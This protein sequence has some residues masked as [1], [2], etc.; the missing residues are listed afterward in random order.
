MSRRSLFLA[1][2]FLLPQTALSRPSAYRAQDPSASVVM[3]FARDA[4]GAFIFTGS[5]F[6]AKPGLVVSLRD[7]RRDGATVFVTRAG[8]DLLVPATPVPARGATSVDV[9]RVAKTRVSP[10]K[11]ASRGAT[12]GEAVVAD[13]ALLYAHAQPSGTMTSA[14]DA[15]VPAVNFP[16]GPGGDAAGAPVLAGDGTVLGL[17][18]R[19]PT[20][21]GHLYVV[22][23][24][25]IAARLD[26]RA[27]P[28][29]IWL[30][31]A[32]RPLPQLPAPAAVQPP[33]P[34]PKP[35]TTPLPPEKTV[36]S[37]VMIQN[38]PRPEYT[39]EAR[40]HR[41]QGSVVVRVLLGANGLVKS[42][43][44]VRGLPD[45]LNE[46]AIEA[47]Y[48][49][50]FTPARNVAG[51]PI[52]SWVTVNV[53]FTI[54][55]TPLTGVWLASAQGSAGTIEFVLDYGPLNGRRGL[56]VLE[57]APGVFTVVYVIGTY[58]NGSFLLKAVEPVRG[59]S[60]EWT[61]TATDGVLIVE[62][63]RLCG[64]ADPRPRSLTF[65][66]RPAAG[67]LVSPPAT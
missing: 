61:G 4:S 12:A 26:G 66:Y 23:A 51:E 20:D 36:S 9:F 45:G 28:D 53:A 39:E 44:V 14:A 54:R 16:T 32:P 37:K 13:V 67:V 18:T 40:T 35:Q 31:V 6:Y 24:A 21:K 17:L 43:S 56:A 55:D 7:A 52:D 48:K 11:L 22:P 8:S 1:I 65:A 3:I 34:A 33:P 38:R 41:T 19:T 60:V 47:V 62:E 30:T 57:D 29:G 58:E 64:K 2:L 46:K 27:E 25:A 15:A 50:E 63:V 49:L 59:C 5:G 42:A 10:L